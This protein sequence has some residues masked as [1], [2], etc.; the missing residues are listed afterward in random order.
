MKSTA[1]QSKRRRAHAI[2]LSFR[3][4][5]IDHRL[6][7]RGLTVTAWAVGL[8]GRRSLRKK[9]EEELFRAAHGKSN[10]LCVTIAGRRE[11]IWFVV[12]WWGGIFPP[13]ECVVSVA[14]DWEKIRD[15]VRE[16]AVAKCAGVYVVRVWKIWKT[17]PSIKRCSFLILHQSFQTAG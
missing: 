2:L 17:E 13:A 16:K 7:L 12:F 11:R 4:Y 8:K 1:P 6:D 14:A 3:G 5:S 10:E 9:R 15:T